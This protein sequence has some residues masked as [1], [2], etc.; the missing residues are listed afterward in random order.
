[1]GW[2]PPMLP[3]RLQG[4][5]DFLRRYK[6]TLALENTIWPGYMTEKLVDPMLVNSIPIYF[7]DPE[8]KKSFDPGSYIDSTCFSSI[9]AMMEFVRAVD[10]FGTAI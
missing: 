5:L 8:A 3:N 10:N 1:M 4:K 9:K 6:F 7:G 2:M